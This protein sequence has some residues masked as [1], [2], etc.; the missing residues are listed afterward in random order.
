[1]AAEHVVGELGAS[2]RCRVPVVGV[3]GLPEH[4]LR[5]QPETATMAPGLAHGSRFVPG[6]VVG[7][8]PP[9][10]RTTPDLLRVGL[11]ARWVGAVDYELLRQE[12]GGAV[13]ALDF[14]E[15]LGGPEASPEAIRDAG[16]KALVA[17]PEDLPAL[18]A[19]AAVSQSA[20][21]AA[22]L[23]VPLAWWGFS[24]DAVRSAVLAYLVDRRTRLL[25]S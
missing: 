25:A 5:A 7:Q 4:V 18:P 24:P 1:M 8:V 11:L 3:V 9:A 14:G 22:V 20:I 10:E 6:L 13:W 16:R 12:P 2:L 23:S 21:T 15:S 19:L 17:S